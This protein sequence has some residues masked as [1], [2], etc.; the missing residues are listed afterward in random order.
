[1]RILVA[2]DNDMV[3]KGVIRIISGVAGWEVCAEAKDGM[4]AVERA[5]ELR[6]DLILLDV[7]MPGTNGLETTRVLRNDLPKS[8]IVIMSQ[9]DPVHLSVSARAAGA[10]ACV[11][12]NRL[13]PDLVPTIKAL[14]AS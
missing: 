5:R 12:K 10:H 1:M 9:H 13:G 8:R 14:L 2:D 11:D 4:E 6:P 7:S 3:R